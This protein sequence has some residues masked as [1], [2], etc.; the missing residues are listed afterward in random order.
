[1]KTHDWQAPGP[2]LW[3]RDPA[4]QTSAWTRYL[5][6]MILPAFD[7]GYR[8]GFARYGVIIDH[9][10]AKIVNGWLFARPRPVGAP[11]KPGNPPPKLVVK[12]LFLLHPELR[13]RAKTAREVFRTRPWRQEAE[14]WYGEE[15][16][17][18]RRR[19]LELQAV[20]L[21]ALDDTELQRHLAAATHLFVEG[22]TIH[23]RHNPAASVPLGD[24]LG[25]A[26]EWTGA[27]PEEALLALNGK[28]P[29]S[30]GM[31]EPLDRLADAIKSDTVALGALHAGGE[32]SSRIEHLRAASPEVRSRWD[33][34]V[35]EYGHRTVTGFDVDDLTLLELPSL[36]ISTVAARVAGRG[37]STPAVDGAAARLRERVPSE[38]R[39][40]YDDLL[41][42]ATLMYG[43][44][45]DDVG[46]GEQWP[47]GLV[48]RALLEAGRR[49]QRNGTVTDVEDVFEATPDEVRAL[50]GSEVNA[51]SKDELDRRA[52]ERREQSAL[53]PP[54]SIGEP[55]GPPPSADVLP[56]ALA[57]VI[58]AMMLSL[59]L[60]VLEQP[61]SE[62]VNGQVTGLGVSS[63]RYA[64]RAC[65][66]R[67]AEDFEK[68]MSGDVLVSQITTPTYNV[69]LPLLGAI[70]TDR[71]AALSHAAIVA[72]E[73]GIPAVVGT[74]DA[75]SRIPDG[76]RVVVDGDRGIVT[77][78]E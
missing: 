28:S 74:N 63:G 7:R 61:S 1:M 37:G 15:R 64:G 29:A 9:L 53:E 75:T 22:T 76:A 66:V 45:D 46:I 32:A 8:E 33:A 49:L 55:E 50:L 54:V 17:G 30:V 16:E 27:S 31:I 24:W 48:R 25:R 51:P 21:E 52:A 72:R 58:N 60:M 42:Q 78:E 19:N 47:L 40:D 73:F 14:R 18:L 4:H 39:A 35:T 71:G 5:C 41:S 20:D 12:A 70:V 11:E 23:F 2:G 57:R 59:N 68:I 6:A 67:G 77:L 43:L 3:M 13:R 62:S 34:Y 69:V 10:D 56:P 44:R 65:V 38:H 36:L 26:I